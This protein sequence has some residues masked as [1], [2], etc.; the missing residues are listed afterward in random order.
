MT[1]QTPAEGIVK[2][3]DWTDA[4]YYKVPCECG[5]NNEIDMMIEVDEF[6]ITATFCSTTKTK[7]WYNRL[8]I[9]YSEPW[10]ILVG[11]QFFN[12]LYNRFTIAWR[13]LV[14]G[15]VETESCVMLSP[16][17]CVN[18]GDTLNTA[19][20]DFEKIVAERQSKINDEKSSS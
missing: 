11:K 1:P 7:Y 14:H 19:V 9:D 4:K 5:C 3:K 12:D 10:L 18:F 17:Q 2:M 8:D 20:K 15:Y 16:Q 6:S 13:G